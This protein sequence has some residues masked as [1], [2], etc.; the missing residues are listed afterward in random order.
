V[1]LGHRRFLQYIAPITLVF[2]LLTPFIPAADTTKDEWPLFRGNALQTGVVSTALPEKLEVLWRFQAKE[3]FDAAVAVSGGVVYAGSLDEHLY[4]I[5]L[6]KG[7]EKWKYRADKSS[8]KAPPS[9]R[10]GAVYIGDGSGLFHCVDAA[11]GTKRWTF[12]TDAEILS[13]ANFT[14]NSV[15]FGSTDETLY[16]L[17]LE[18][19]LSWKFK[20]AGPIYGSPSVV[21]DRTFVGGCDS[22]IHVLDV[23]NGKELLSVD[24]GGQSGSTPAVAGDRIYLGT[25]TDEVQAVDW[26]KGEIAWTFRPEKGAQQFLSSAAVT[27]SLVVIG[28]QDRRVWALKRDSGKEAWSFLTGGRVDASPVVAGDRVYAGSLDGKLYVLELK[29]GQ[30]IQK[31]ALDGAISASPAVVGDRLLIGTQKGT[32]YC[33]GA[34]K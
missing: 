16:C 4:A 3:G 13:G 27:D 21:G 26:K 32:L 12:E 29:T 15:L 19:K 25:R 2:G 18:G 6:D 33:L 23:T 34:K 31:I 8:F 22:L 9:V 14:K 17:N 20:I 30:Q 7:T 24:L 11:K 1:T 28:S 10:D 5:D